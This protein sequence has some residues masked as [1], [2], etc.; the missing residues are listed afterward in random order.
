MRRAVPSSERHNIHRP[1]TDDVLPR[2]SSLYQLQARVSALKR[3]LQQTQQSDC[4][5]RRKKDPYKIQYL[6]SQSLPSN[7]ASSLMPQ[8]QYLTWLTE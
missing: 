1:S 2:L 7:A 4:Q 3:R 6:A 5:C 8:R